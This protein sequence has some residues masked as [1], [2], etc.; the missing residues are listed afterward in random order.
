VPAARK[1]ENE[2]ARLAALYE[3]EL[4]DTPMEQRF[5]SITQL[6]VDIFDVAFSAIIFV[7]KER[8]WAKSSSLL[9]QWETPRTES[10]CAHTILQDQPL[11]IED[12]RVDPQVADLSCVKES[13]CFYAGV[14]L[15]SPKGYNV[16]TLCLADIKPRTFSH[17]QRTILARL[18]KIVESKFQSASQLLLTR[19]L[20]AAERDLNVATQA[21]K[22]NERLGTLRNATL[23]LIAKNKALAVVLH[24]IVDGVEHQF[25]QMRCSILLLDK[26]KQQFLEGV[27]PSLPDFYNDAIKTIFI[28]EGVGSCGTAAVT[29]QR[30]IAEDIQSH[31]YWRDFKELAAQAGLASCW[32][33]PILNGHDDVLGTFAIYHQVPNSP[34]ALELRLIEQSAHLASIAIEHDKAEKLILRQANYDFLTGLAN[35]QLFAALI[36]TAIKQSKRK[37]SKFSLL[38]L[39]LD[40]FKQVNDTLGHAVGDL[41]LIETAQRL[42]NSVRES[43]SVARLGGDEFVVL[44]NNVTELDNV[45][46]TAKKIKCAL[47]TP[48]IIDSNEINVSSSIGITHY[49]NDGDTYEVLLKNADLAMYQ[50]KERGRNGYQY[51]VASM[52]KRH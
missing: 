40:H 18:G 29:K 3:L 25:P 5:D 4:L 34:I 13:L 39:D 20:L 19:Q 23:E 24:S 22:D 6:A 36:D 41:L 27:A 44:L 49:P 30:V 28:G 52:R 35:R 37:S 50:A 26:P 17:Q 32:S 10:I 45:A 31:P 14:P 42:R 9:T 43:D 47:A 33:Q 8:Q 38:F 11:I 2:D 51:F 1:P 12:T 16:A 46:H 48:F 7:D 15:K 21:L